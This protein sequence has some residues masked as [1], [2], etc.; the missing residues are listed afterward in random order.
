MLVT[1]SITSG[2]VFLKRN[3]L[4]PTKM[5]FFYELLSYCPQTECH[6]KDL[7]VLQI[8]LF[9]L[10]VQGSPPSFTFRIAKRIIEL[11]DLQD[12][13][14][15]KADNLSGG[16]KRK[17][18]LAIALISVKSLILLD[19]PTTGVDPMARRKIWHCL[20]LHRRIGKFG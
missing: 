5:P 16:N 7:T 20:N 19:E 6:F 2:Q 1:G 17:L 9:Y 13:S 18:S 14:N 3:H 4:K 11:T 15:S 12:Y 8:I 10:R